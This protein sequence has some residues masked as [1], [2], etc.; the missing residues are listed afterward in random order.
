MPVSVEEYIS[1]AHYYS[2]V[3]LSDAFCVTV[4]SMCVAA[5]F[6]HGDGNL[7]SRRKCNVE[8]QKQ[9]DYGVLHACSRLH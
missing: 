6:A 4:A 3:V 5:A 8:C 1:D 9:V 2:A 7:P